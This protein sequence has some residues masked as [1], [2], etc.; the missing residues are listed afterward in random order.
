MTKNNISFHDWLSEYLKIYLIK[1]RHYSEKTLKAYKQAFNQI[2]IYFDTTLNIKFVNM[3]FDNFN[4][5]NIYSFLAYLKNEKGC[6]INTINLRL[7]AFKSFL[8]Y[9]AEED[10]ELYNYYVKVKSI[11]RF[12]GGK[13]NKLEYLTTDQVKL[14]LNEPDTK[15]R[16]GKRNQFL[17]I[18]LYETGIRLDELLNLKLNDIYRFDNRIEIRVL[19]KGNKVKRIPILEGVV[20]HLDNYLKQFHD[21]SKAD[22]YLFYTKHQNLKTKMCPGTVDA[23]LKNMRDK[24]MKKRQIFHS[25]YTHICLDIQ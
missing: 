12:K 18:M 25:T 11:H 24:F 5:D 21:N 13:N 20:V 10:I 6:S 15:L 17:M 19:G 9:C 4:K 16:I 2:R 22:E 1:K 8:K 7:S 23:I 3:N 14:L